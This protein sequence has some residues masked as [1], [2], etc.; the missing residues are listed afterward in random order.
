LTGKR[1]PVKPVVS[2]FSKSRAPIDPGVV[3]APTTAMDRGKKM[4]S[5]EAATALFSLT[6][7]AVLALRE[8]STGKSTVKTPSS[9]VRVS[10]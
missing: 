2:R 4:G 9:R 7:S 5:N 1:G 8:R 3:E 6:S 10:R